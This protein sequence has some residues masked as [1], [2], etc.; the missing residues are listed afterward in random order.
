MGW[1]WNT[2]RV[3]QN[4][5]CEE[6]EYLYLF[7]VEICPLLT[8]MGMGDPQTSGVSVGFTVNQQKTGT[9]IYSKRFSAWLWP[10]TI[11]LTS[12]SCSAHRKPAGT[13]QVLRA[14]VMLT[15]DE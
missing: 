1:R 4:K 2:K 3:Y 12:R 9:L 7:M 8:F 14:T 11:S 6:C 10:P 15:P 5:T 13:R